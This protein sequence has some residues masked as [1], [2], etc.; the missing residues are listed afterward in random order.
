MAQFRAVVRC[1]HY[2]GPRVRQ[3][4]TGL[5]H[6]TEAVTLRE[7]KEAERSQQRGERQSPFLWSMPPITCFF[8]GGLTS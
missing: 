2:F 6:V 8:Q 5:G 7:S 1:V 4:T 3:N